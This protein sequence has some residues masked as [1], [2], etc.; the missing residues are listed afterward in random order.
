MTLALQAIK[1][2]YPLIICCRFS[3]SREWFQEFAVLLIDHW[4]FGFVRWPLHRSVWGSY[5]LHHFHIPYQ[6]WLDLTVSQESPSRIAYVVY[7]RPVLLWTRKVWN[8]WTLATSVWRKIVHSR[9]TWKSFFTS[10]VSYHIVSNAVYRSELKFRLSCRT[11]FPRM[12]SAT[13]HNND[14]EFE[15]TLKREEAWDAQCFHEEFY[16]FAM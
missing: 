8:A 7:S 10:C 2:V 15:K 13:H 11:W 16:P 9:D 3:C 6:A 1:R 4:N 5:P 14:V 12:N